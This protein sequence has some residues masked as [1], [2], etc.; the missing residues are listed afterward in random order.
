MTHSDLMPGDVVI[1][2][3]DAQPWLVLER[4]ETGA[5]RYLLL[6]EGTTDDD[7]GQDHRFHPAVTVLRQGEDVNR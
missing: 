6:F 2:L 7:D 4:L 1:G 5:L 3:D